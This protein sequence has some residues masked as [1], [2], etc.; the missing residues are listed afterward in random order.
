MR[1]NDSE[2]L[3]VTEGNYIFYTCLTLVLFIAAAAIVSD[4][5]AAIK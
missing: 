3:D 2:R 5:F 4:L 1:R